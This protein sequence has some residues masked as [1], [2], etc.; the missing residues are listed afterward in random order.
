METPVRFESTFF[1]DAVFLSIKSLEERGDTTF[2][3]RFNAEKDS[4]YE[5]KADEKAFQEFYE[6]Q[7][8]RLDLGAAFESILSQHV[9]FNEPSLTF[10]VRRIFSRKHEGSELFV[11]GCAKTVVLNIQVERFMEPEYLTNFLKHEFLRV[12]DM[13]DPAFEYSPEAPLGGVN[14]SENNLIRERF[15]A[16]W[17][18]YIHSRLNGGAFFEPGR[19]TQGRLISMARDERTS[20]GFKDGGLICSLCGFPSFDKIGDWSEPKKLRV[21]K[22]IQEDRPDWDPS[23]D[24]CRQCFEMIQARGVPRDGRR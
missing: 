5:K 12:S 19:F 6:N 24:S 7:F 8:K 9:F 1:E 2:V 4:F 10:F 11:D 3:Q 13:L 22:S 23:M 17:N 20:K 15:S 14:D 21:A 18:R 16:L